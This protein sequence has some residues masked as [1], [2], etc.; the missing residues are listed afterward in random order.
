RGC[1]RREAAGL[2]GPG[3]RGERRVEDVDVERDEDGAPADAFADQAGEAAWPERPQ[4][5]ARENGEAEL[6]R[7]LDVLG[8]VERAAQSRLHRCRGVDQT[9]LLRPLERRA[10]EVALAALPVP[11]VAVGAT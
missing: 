3:P 4:L 10:V 5:V 1:R 7:R 9:L 8:A 6:A 11:R 2:G